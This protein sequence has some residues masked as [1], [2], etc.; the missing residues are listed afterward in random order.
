MRRFLSGVVV[1]LVVLFGGTYLYL[2]WG[3]LNFQADR[4][5]S[6]LETRQAMA[7]LDASTARHAPDRENPVEPTE[8][9][10]S[11]GMKLYRSHCAMCHGAPDHPEKKFGHP[12]YPP[13][14]PFVK[15]PKNRQD[16]EQI[17]IILHGVRWT[18]MPAWENTLDERT[19]WTVVTF[20]DHMNKLPPSVEE[21]WKKP[22]SV[23]SPAGPA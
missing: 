19:I 16:S 8:A 13:A 2:R 21:E 12:F 5:P 17:Y 20:L 15:D 10:L 9:N 23:E 4:H 1:T 18:G 6:A 14:P 3:F 11:D 22:P 7:F